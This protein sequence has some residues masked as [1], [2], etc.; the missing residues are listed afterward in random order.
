MNERKKGMWKLLF[1]LD[2]TKDVYSDRHEF[3]EKLL[4]KNKQNLIRN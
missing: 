4:I 2:I 3:T 1:L